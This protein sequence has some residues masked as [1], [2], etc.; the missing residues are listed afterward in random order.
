MEAA[1]G[2]PQV[3][4]SSCDQANPVDRT[5][6][7]RCGSPLATPAA[8]APA[9]TRRRTVPPTLLIA[10]GVLVGVAVVA[11]VVVL[12]TPR[13]EDP[14]S[15]EVA[16]VPTDPPSD[17]ATASAAP[18]AAAP[19][20]E[21]P[22]TPTAPPVGPRVIP[23]SEV[24][25]SA[26]STLDPDGDIRYDPEVTLDGDPATAWND[27]VRGSPVGEWIEW[28]FDT[29]TAVSSIQVVN[30]YDKIDPTT[31]EDRFAQNARIA[32]ARLTTDTEERAVRLSDQREP[33]RLTGALAPTCAVRLTVDSVHAG[34]EF[35]DVAL[36]EIVFIGTPDPSRSCEA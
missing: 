28:R 7:A 27:G 17:A 18:S 11:A 19:G 13:G 30:G 36:S 22:A 4:C 31:G 2:G 12:L 14:V 23:A 8:A 24:T 26:S 25:A 29:P 3:R 9:E 32:D 33:Q 20:N 15:T 34:D 10:V 21:T 35:E 6:C 1:P 16:A 5:Y